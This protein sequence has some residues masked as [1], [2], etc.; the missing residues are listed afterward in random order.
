MKDIM[1]DC[2][3]CAGSGKVKLPDHLF[4]TLSVL[5]KIRK[6]TAPQLKKLMKDPIGFTG[7]NERLDTLY[8]YGLVARERNGRSWVYRAL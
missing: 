4:R 8:L 6:A 3:S 1:I 7:F 2:H 5:R